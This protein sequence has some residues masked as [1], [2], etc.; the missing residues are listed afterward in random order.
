[1]RVENLDNL[2]NWVA[3]DRP[4]VAGESKGD[5]PSLIFGSRFNDLPR[6]ASSWGVSGRVALQASGN[7]GKNRGRCTDARTARQ[8]TDL[9]LC[10]GWEGGSDKIDGGKGSASLKGDR[11]SVRG[12]CL[13]LAQMAARPSPI[14]AGE[15]R[16]MMLMISTS[17]EW[18]GVVE[19][20]AE[21]RRS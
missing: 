18:R 2:E 8:R 21:Q 10:L 16:A 14:E 12:S 4:Q 9:F 3:V 6:C 15:K 11:Q 1:M 7:P 5:D 19:M 17:C 13:F 20:N